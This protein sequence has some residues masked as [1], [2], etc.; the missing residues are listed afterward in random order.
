MTMV[1][2]A[3]EPTESILPANARNTVLLPNQ[4]AALHSF[5]IEEL[6]VAVEVPAG[7]TGQA[8]I[9]GPPGTYEYVCDVPGHAEAGMVGTLTLE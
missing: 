3:F 8:T 1:D 9:V 5:V 7:E 6:D 4:G 2:I